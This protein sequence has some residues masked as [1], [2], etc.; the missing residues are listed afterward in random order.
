[1]QTHR[2]THTQM[3]AIESKIHGSFVNSLPN[4]KIY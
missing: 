2:H 1:M 3:T 4:D